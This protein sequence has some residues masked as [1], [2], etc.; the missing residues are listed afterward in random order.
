MATIAEKE[1]GSWNELLSGKN[2]LRAIA[3]A[4]GVILHATDVYLATT[5]MPSVIEEIGGLSFYS[6]ATTIYVVA[7]IIGSV[8][9]SSNL[10]KQGPK[11]AYTLA[12][13]IF[14]IGAVI[15]TLA[16]AMYILLIGRF[17]Q[18]IGG[19]LLFALSYAMIGILFQEKLWPRAMALVSAMWG[20]STFFGPLIG[21]SFAQYS[22]WRMAFLTL[23]VCALLLIILIQVVLPKS[24]KETKALPVIPWSKLILITAAT[25]AVSMGAAS[26]HVIIKLSGILI[27]VVLFVI[28]VITD[29]KSTNSLLPRG[30]YNMTSSLGATYMIMALLTISTA[31]E[32]YI[33]YFMREIHK[34][35]PLKAGYLTVLIGLG[36]SLSSVFFSGAKQNKVIRLIS[37]GIMIVFVG[38]CGL[39]FIIPSFHSTNGIGF[40]AMC[41][42]LLSIGVGVGMGWPH[43]LTK[44]LSSAPKGE[45][46][47]ASA[48]ITTVQ[49][50]STAFGTALCGLVA[51]ATGILTPGGVSGSQ[52]AALWLFGLFSIAPLMAIIIFRKINK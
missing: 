16:P 8:I 39:S 9:S 21:G 7:A 49:L 22:H 5:I 46:E 40:V 15:C 28:M 36:W 11:K 47:K 17:I 24:I 1:K 10:I 44:V 19:G 37:I 3:L 42:F 41:I 14:A 32:I 29:K 26:T 2:G 50:F 4:A 51:N 35:G 20:V 45:E 27:A 31:V 30:S 18:G 23:A 52:Q 6:W 48:S 38:L 13:L 43:L 34:F 12:A 33:P 25:L